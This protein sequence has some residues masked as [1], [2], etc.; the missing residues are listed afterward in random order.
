MAGGLG[1]G[2][3]RSGENNGNRR[4]GRR[5]RWRSKQPAPNEGQ[6]DHRVHDRATAGDGRDD[7]GTGIDAKTS[8]ST[9]K[10]RQPGKG[11]EQGVKGK[12]SVRWAREGTVRGMHGGHDRGV[13]TRAEKMENW[14]SEASRRLTQG[15][16]TGCRKQWPQVRADGVRNGQRTPR[17]AKAKAERSV[18]T[19]PFW[20][21]RSGGP[22]ITRT[23][24]PTSAKEGRGPAHARRPDSADA[25][26]PPN[27]HCCKRR[28]ARKRPFCA[29]P[30]LMILNFLLYLAMVS[31][32]L[33]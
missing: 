22:P 26:R 8:V 19:A 4:P 12:G 20:A 24:V 5:Y 25:V 2:T 15:T 27:S 1:E 13:G 9:H 11:A 14:A 10:G 21:A 18:H 29:T 32:F 31:A 6:L 16:D 7:A 23:Q 30:S 33:P 3:E 17:H 28:A